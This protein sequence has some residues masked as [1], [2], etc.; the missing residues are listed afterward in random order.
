MPDTSTLPQQP[1]DNP[2]H[3]QRSVEDMAGFFRGRS[4]A[5]NLKLSDDTNPLFTMQ[6]T[7]KGGL[8]RGLNSSGELIF[9][10]DDSGFQFSGDG[11]ARASAQGFIVG[12]V[13]YW[14]GAPQD[15]PAGWTIVYE[16]RFPIGASQSATGAA[17]SFAVGATGGRLDP[18]LD[19]D[20]DH[21]HP[22]P[23][24]GVPRETSGDTFAGGGNSW[25]TA[26]THAVAINALGTT[27]VSSR[28]HAG[29]LAGANLPPWVALYL[30][31][32]EA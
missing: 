10:L 1:S 20:I 5:S 14:A 3:T 18:L 30:I 23:V 6:N 31:R 25:R 9:Q 17:G 24:T 11:K 19:V 8:L 7:G 27:L 32:K 29:D 15:V 2:E 16:G 4:F 13:M 12:M 22:N 21:N 28:L 26:H